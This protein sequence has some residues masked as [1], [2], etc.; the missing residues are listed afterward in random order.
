MLEARRIEAGYGSTRVLFGVDLVAEKGKI[1]TVIGPNGAGKT[2][3]LLTLAGVL[4]ETSGEVVL[5]G[6]RLNGLPAWKRV[7]KGLVLC[8]ERRRLFPGLTVLDNLMLGAF[9]RRDTD[10][11]TKDLVEVY[12]LFPIL[13]ARSGQLAGTLSGGEQQMVA[14]GRAL[15]SHPKVLML[16]EPSVGLSPLM[17]SKI[18]EQITRVRE[19]SGLTIVLVEQDAADAL[20]ISDIA[21][22]LEDGRVTLRGK[23]SELAS[24]PEVRAAYL[25]L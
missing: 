17:R 10:L 1:T 24:D 11:I 4:R 15:M 12:S 3:L 25:G 14:I 9:S 13:K 8:P 21:C 2:T 20:A 5:A 23:G 6:E 18:F 22:V 16:D 19:L 7:A